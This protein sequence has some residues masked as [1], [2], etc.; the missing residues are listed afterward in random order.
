MSNHHA[1]SLAPPPKAKERAARIVEWRVPCVTTKNLGY[2]NVPV[3]GEIISKF[4]MSTSG[5]VDLM[6]STV[7]HLLFVAPV[8]KERG[9]RQQRL[10]CGNSGS[11][12]KI[13][14]SKTRKDD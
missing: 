14:G 1:L 2:M 12:P 3:F 10:S 13:R 6:V 11:E 7:L 4:R 5:D 9:I 8:L